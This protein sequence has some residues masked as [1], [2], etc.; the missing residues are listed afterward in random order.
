VDTNVAEVL[1]QNLPGAQAVLD[2]KL[3]VKVGNRMFWSLAR[4]GS[5]DGNGRSLREIFDPQWNPSGLV[6]AL[7]SLPRGDYSPQKATLMEELAP[8]ETRHSPGRGPTACRPAGGSILLTIESPDSGTLGRRMNRRERPL[9][10]SA[11]FVR[12]LL[13]SARRSRDPPGGAASPGESARR[14]PDGLEA[15]RGSARRGPLGYLTL[16]SAGTI[17]D[18]NITAGRMLGIDPDKRRAGRSPPSL[19]R[20]TREPFSTTCRSA[21]G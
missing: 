9:R 4:A 12:E 6:S 15:V 1:V 17:L 7:E 21:A 11:S 18:C 20:S 13:A 2:S 3:R 10:D 19:H 5:K 14:S 8:G 16:D